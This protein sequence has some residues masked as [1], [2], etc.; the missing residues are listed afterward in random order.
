MWFHDDDDEEKI[1]RKE[2]KETR[3]VL[4]EHFGLMSLIYIMSSEW[5]SIWSTI[6]LF[7]K[8][9]I[10]CSHPLQLKLLGGYCVW[11]KYLKWDTRNPHNIG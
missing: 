11:R 1:S 6:K 5:N 10:L 7:D 3:L 8:K 9:S 2:Y 4:W